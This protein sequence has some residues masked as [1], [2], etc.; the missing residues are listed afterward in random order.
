MAEELYAA[1]QDLARKLGPARAKLF[2]GYAEAVARGE[3]SPTSLANYWIGCAVTTCRRFSIE[4]PSPTRPERGHPDRAWE[5]G[6]PIL[7]SAVL[8]AWER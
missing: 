6:A 8:S 4:L 1:A 3:I 2:W 5:A 7:F